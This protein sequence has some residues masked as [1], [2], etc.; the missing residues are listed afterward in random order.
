MNIDTYPRNMKDTEYTKGNYY[1]N[2][3][4]KYAIQINDILLSE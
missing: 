2:I 4:E 1:I 3:Y